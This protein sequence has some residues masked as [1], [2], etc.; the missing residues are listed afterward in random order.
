MSYTDSFIYNDKNFNDLIIYKTNETNSDNIRILKNKINELNNKINFISKN[1]KYIDNFFEQNISCLINNIDKIL[2]Y[3]D[4][5]A[6]TNG[7][8][9][10]KNKINNIELEI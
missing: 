10:Y 7:Q 6:V 8:L 9:R 5:I 3:V 1:S 2:N 4:V